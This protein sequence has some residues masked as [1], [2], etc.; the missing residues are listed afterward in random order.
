[1]KSIEIKFIC[2]DKYINELITEMSRAISCNVD[3][4][5]G[6][7]ICSLIQI[8][9]FFLFEFNDWKSIFDKN[10]D[11]NKLISIKINEKEPII[12]NE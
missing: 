11:E 3:I 7:I 1:L 6:M 8:F 2:G 9:S 12:N 4:S 10:Y 5:I